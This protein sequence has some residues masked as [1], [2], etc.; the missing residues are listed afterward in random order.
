[1]TIRKSQRP[2]AI[3]PVLL[4]GLLGALAACSIAQPPTDDPTRYFVLSDAAAQQ[5]PAAAGGVRIG[6]RAVRLEGYLKRKEIVV[7]TGENEVEF[8][9][10]RRWAEPLDAGIARIVRSRL[11]ASPGVA[12][13]YA[14]PFPLDQDRDFDVLV[15]VRK[16]EGS[17]TPSGTWAASLSATIEVSTAGA[18]PHVVARRTFL[19]PLAAWDGSDFDRLASLLSADVSALGQEVLA[20]IPARN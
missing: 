10:F 11:L 4:L 5:A 20:E 14:E 9:D 7:R 17:L 8:R 1:M 6:L 3:F 13:V 12:Q 19:A 18:N 16:C 2:A 15:E